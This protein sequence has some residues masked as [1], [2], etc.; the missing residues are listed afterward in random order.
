MN[1]CGNCHNWKGLDVYENKCE[2]KGKITKG[3]ETCEFWYSRI[4]AMIDA[5]NR[6]A[7][8]LEGVSFE[9]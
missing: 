9:R 8:L 3:E 7:K 1:M 5:D 4:K 2:K 6:I